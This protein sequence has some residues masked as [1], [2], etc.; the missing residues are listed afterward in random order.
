MR[1]QSQRTVVSTFGR[2]GF[3]CFVLLLCPLPL[4]ASTHQID[5][6]ICREELSTARRELLAAKLR[7]ITGLA[8]EFDA[9]SALRSMPSEARGE[10][11]TARELL[12]KALNGTRV[13]ILEDASDRQDVVFS[14]VIP[15]RLKHHSSN[16]PQTYV[17][18]I[19][20]TDFDRLL[21]DEAALRAF[22]VGWAFLHELDHVVNDLS[23]S[24]NPT[25]TG[26]C[27]TH[28]NMMR[29]ELD[30][31][32]RA[33]YFYVLFPDAERSEFRTRFV[34]LPFEQTDGATKKRHRYWVMWDALSVGGLSSQIAAAVP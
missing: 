1:R 28:I 14:R 5:T 6:I 31:P 17:V 4:F 27:E 26:E 3:I 13:L 20:F 25:E 15:G 23:D 16:S 11:Q 32:I 9:N 10:S 12:R 18:L 21:G 19:D 22:D 24:P 30:L 34:R 29:R 8:V 33:N 2:F 7:T